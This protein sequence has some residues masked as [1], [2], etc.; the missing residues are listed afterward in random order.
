MDRSIY[1][2]YDA[3]ETESFAVCRHTLRKFAPDVPIHAISLEEMRDA[4]L[5]TRP[6]STRIDNKTGA[7]RLY[8]EISEHAMS[9]EFAISRFLTPVLA[10]AA[11]RQG[12]ALFMD[13]DILARDDID[14][15]FAECDP[16]KAVMCVQHQH[17]PT[18]DTKMD[19]QLQTLYARK[20]WSSVML[21]NLSHPANRKLTVELINK[22]PGRD[23]HRFCWLEDHEIGALGQEWNYLAG[24]TK[25]QPGV[26]PKLIHF[27]EGG[28]W[29]E[30]YRDVEFAD[31]WRAARASWLNEGMD[32]RPTARISALAP[33]RLNGALR[34]SALP[35]ASNGSVHAHF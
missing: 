11:F 6:T 13:C 34:A 21:F 15:L 30:D 7:A 26:E 1:I 29:F 9:T 33:R 19:G 24:Y 14:D 23:L 4:G 35:A 17:T 25:L 18:S 8:D 3:R 22:V 2:G 16:S 28:P 20:N 31:E 5:Y 32:T 12:W 27:T 10:K